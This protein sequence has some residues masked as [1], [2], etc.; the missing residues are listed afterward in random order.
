MRSL[1]LIAVL[2]SVAP[3][4]AQNWYVPD[5]DPTTG[6]CNVIPFGQTVGSAFYQA[7]YQS[8]FTAA[9]L[10]AAANLITGLGFAS[11]SSGRAHYDQM[12]VVLDHIPAAQPT[13]TTFASNL[14]PAA[15]TVLNV[16]NYTWNLTAN[17][18]NEIGLQNFF[19]YNG[20]DD[21]IVQIT[22]V[23][24]IAPAGFR[25]ATRERIYWIAAS[26]TPP[27]TG[28]SGLAASKVEVS[29]LMGRTSSHGDGCPGS[30]GTPSVNF[31]GSPQVGNTISF[32]LTNGVSSGIGLFIAGTV[33]SFP[34][35]I[36]LAGFGAP[37]C[38][39]YTDLAFTSAVLLDPAGAGSV[40]V[41]IPAGLTGFR[42]YSQ[43]AVLDLP[44]NQFGF[45]TS[46]YLHVH[47]GN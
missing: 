22:M 30:N 24:G 8:R 40:A 21:V 6:T 34:F 2:A 4:F 9:D 44:A 28:T 27:A 46:N 33:N 29:M 18:W 41:P 7:K 45:T 38:Y 20:V 17:A 32:D 15:V 39:A 37:G 19:V 36:D 12:E 3:A 16:S 13:S 11:C 14:T 43:Y 42:F 31:T 26:G 47:T 1:C 25:R 5:N 23:N 35:P 10:G